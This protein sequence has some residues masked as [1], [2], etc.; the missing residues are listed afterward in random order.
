MILIGASFFSLMC[1]VGWTGK[2]SYKLVLNESV[3][4]R[5]P[6]LEVL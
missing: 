3:H 6:L 4:I 1:G 2:V 5:C